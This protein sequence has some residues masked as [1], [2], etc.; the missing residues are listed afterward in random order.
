MKQELISK[1]LKILVIED[2]ISDF[3]LLNF[4]LSEHID[5][6]FHYELIHAKSLKLGLEKLNEQ[7]FDL[8]L[9]DLFLP[10]SE[11]LQ[12]VK[13]LTKEIHNIPIIVLTGL[14]DVYLGREAVRLGAQEYLVKGEFN[15]NLLVQSILHSIERHK[16]NDTIQ[17]LVNN[18]KK[19]EKKLR[20]I[21]ESQKDGILIVDEEG[22]VKFVN[23]AAERLFNIEREE[24]QGTNFGFPIHDGEKTEI[25]IFQGKEKIR[26]GELNSVDIDWEGTP[27]SLLNIRD[28]TEHK[29]FQKLLKE[30]ENKYRK[31]FEKSPYP[32]LI[33][34]QDERIIDCNSD[35][36]SL[37][38]IN[39]DKIINQKIKNTL[40][41][42]IVNNA[43]FK[44][45]IHDYDLEVEPQDIKIKKHNGEEI[46][47]NLKFS[48][49]H[50]NKKLLIHIL[51]E[52]V[53]EIKE[54]K[55]HVR[56][57]E[58]TLHEMNALI[59]HAPLAIFLMT[60]N[61]KILRTNEEAVKLFNCTEKELISSKIYDLFLQE[62]LGNV[63]RHYNKDIYN[64]RIDNKIESKINRKSGKIVNVEVIST[65]LKIANNIIIQSFISNITERKNS[66]RNREFLLDQLIKS[67]EFKSK[68]LAAM[69]HDLR[70]PLNAI[71]G[72][73]SLL[74]DESYGKLN[75]DQ[76]DYLEDI[77]SAAEHLTDLIDSILDVSKIDIGEFKL[78][79]KRFQLQSLIEQIRSVIDPL[80][81]KKGLSFKTFNITPDIKI[82]AD[83]V[84][85]KQV[86]Y[87][88]LENAIK[89]TN[90]GE[91]ILKL[92]E[93]DDH[94]EFRVSDTG[95][96]IEKDDYEV[97][98]RE[99]GR[100]EDDINKEVSGSGI[101]LALTK[102]LIELHGGEIWF[103]SKKNEG[104]TFYFTIPKNLIDNMEEENILNKN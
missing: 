15:S 41:S 93:Y 27:A 42:P 90:D 23:L 80:Y 57:L 104:T 67:L 101:G 100:V 2:N 88:L 84:R 6:K 33:L 46:W 73:S 31:L 82:C 91:I 77:Y 71:V 1:K 36:E 69:S 7:N 68:F 75:L 66:E 43:N 29:K 20:K 25:N 32:I 102:R 17:K 34:D 8:V 63:K 95:I 79:K 48:K 13:I 78:N 89:F 44:N 4:Q 81:K 61:G 56:V 64:L 16:L 55:E 99:F 60:Q 53:T 62:D 14:N 26:F 58:Q 72:F 24:F 65:T 35:L 83:P 51:I 22:K 5:L 49:I 74:L 103:K 39:K 9:L 87:N 11:G 3:E 92:I 45:I 30:S 21:I 47:V 54:S 37:I 28:I 94:W 18:V 70:T 96:G 38:G 19:E 59:E 52:N 50:T 86:L 98:F 85:I 40:L 12:T 97:V 10:D 76:K